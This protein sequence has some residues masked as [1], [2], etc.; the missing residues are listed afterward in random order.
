VA[1]LSLASFAIRS[2]FVDTLSGF[3]APSCFS[4]TTLLTT[5]PRFPRPGPPQAAFPDVNSTI[6]ALRLPVPTT[7]PHIYSLV[8][9]N[10]ASPS[11]LPRSAS[12][13][14]FAC[15]ASVL[16][17]SESEHQLRAW[18]DTAVYTFAWQMTYERENGP[19]RES[20][21]DQLVL[22]RI[23]ACWRVLFRYIYFSPA[24]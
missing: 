1:G 18:P 24:V 14:E 17:Y 19:K 15:N 3:K 7:D 20:G 10:F 22:G 12:Y 21:T 8:P 13:R 4:E 16:D 23:G 9:S 5:V 11:S 2:C 6:R